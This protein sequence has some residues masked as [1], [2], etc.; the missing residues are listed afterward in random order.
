MDAGF[1][2]RFQMVGGH[3]ALFRTLY[4]RFPGF[5][6]A[7]ALTLN[8]LGPPFLAEWAEIM[9]GAKPKTAFLKP[10]IWMPIMRDLISL[11]VA[12]RNMTAPQQAPDLTDL[13]ATMSKRRRI[14][15]SVDAYRA[16]HAGTVADRQA[17]Y[18]EVVNGR[19][20][21]WRRISTNMAG[22]NRFILPSRLPA[23]CFVTR[24]CGMSRRD[25]R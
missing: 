9:T 17:E 21:I 24:S 3:C 10:A 7:S 11:T 23:S 19:I 5:L 4:A 6:D 8:R 12:A 22:G 14:D 2:S 25:R 1:W 16:Q 18:A 20:P 13:S 15:A